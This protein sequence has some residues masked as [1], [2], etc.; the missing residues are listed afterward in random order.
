MKHL[1]TLLAIISLISLSFSQNKDS[2]VDLNTYLRNSTGNSI[3]LSPAIN[4]DVDGNPY[5][6]EKWAN[7]GFVFLKDKKTVSLTNFNYNA[8]S[9][10]FE[11]KVGNDST[12]V[13]SNSIADSIAINNKVFI[14][15][16]KN[17]SG[18]SGYFEVL[19]KDDNSELLKKYVTE[20]KKAK[21][22]AITGGFDFP[23]KVTI[24]KL[25]YIKTDF[26]YKE[27]SLRKHDLL[28]YFEKNKS[29]IKEFV[30]KNNL[31]YNNQADVVKMFK[32]AATL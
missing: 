28:D 18:V 1:F 4:H 10:Q 5:L 6:F 32:F 26:G 14:Y 17:G 16:S 31:S 22:N 15:L 8:Y 30:Q 24:E 19:F 27:I 11:A 25:F 9:D 2:N 21:Q 12:F 20:L 29:E 13:F 3:P 7:R 23:D